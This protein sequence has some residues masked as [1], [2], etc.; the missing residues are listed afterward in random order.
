MNLKGVRVLL[1]EDNPINQEVTRSVLAQAG[2]VVTVVNDGRE[3]VD[4]V[5][6]ESFDLVLMDCQMPV[7][8][9]YEA[10]RLLRRQEQLR[11]MP[12]IA[13]TASAMAGDRDKALA[14]GMNDHV[15]KPLD[16]D[17]M[18]DTI[19]R[20]TRPAATAGA[21]AAPAAA[22]SDLDAVPGIDAA[23]W[24]KRRIGDDVMYRRLL[25][26]FLQEQQGFATAFREALAAGDSTA[27]VRLAHT[28]KSLSSMLG[29][30]GVERAAQALES[31]C[32]DKSA[33]KDTEHLLA[34]VS[35]ELDPVMEG[36]RKI[37]GRGG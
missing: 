8:D 27:A 10:T 5:G 16:I 28:L 33:C 2:I 7:M 18:F 36:L 23:A 4:I 1:V 32:A 14:A 15:R 35:R 6:R 29:V 30:H 24:R 17:E 21:D 9:G 26:R 12:I 25:D 20:W 31:A 3:A 13:M 34:D 19:A 22:A 11:R 37:G